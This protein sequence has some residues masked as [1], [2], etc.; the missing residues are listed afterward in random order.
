MFILANKRDAQTV[1][2]PSRKGT[3]SIVEAQRRKSDAKSA[4]DPCIGRVPFISGLRVD[5]QKDER[6][7]HPSPGYPLEQ[8]EAGPAGTGGL[9][10]PDLTWMGLLP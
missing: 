1:N 8:V 6:E 2:Q 3:Q 7:R 10:A 4:G 9:Q 5:S